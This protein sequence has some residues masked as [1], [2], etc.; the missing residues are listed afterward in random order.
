[1]SNQTVSERK[2][3]SYSEFY[4]ELPP[5]ICVDCGSKIKEQHESY[6]TK[7][8]HCLSKESE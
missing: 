1:M 4:K 7:C 5:K 8:E 3:S 2:V 6:M